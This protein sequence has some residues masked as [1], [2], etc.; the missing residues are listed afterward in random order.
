MVGEIVMARWYRVICTLT[1]PLELIIHYREERV[2]PA[3]GRSGIA[4]VTA[5]Y[6]V[7]LSLRCVMFKSFRLL[8]GMYL[9]KRRQ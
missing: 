9:T 6:I 7:S 2:L 8:G 1:H 5:K 3:S 4:M